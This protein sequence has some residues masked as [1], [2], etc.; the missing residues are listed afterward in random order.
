[1]NTPF[2]QAGQ[3]NMPCVGDK[4]A[5]AACHAK[6]KMSSFAGRGALGLRDVYWPMCRNGDGNLALCPRENVGG[7]DVWET[8]GNNAR[9]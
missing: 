4:A 6:V 3:H 8:H 1:M 7:G 9:G 2:R 5:T